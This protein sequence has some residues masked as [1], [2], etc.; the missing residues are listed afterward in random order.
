[1]GKNFLRKSCL[2]LSLIFSISS[3]C[4]YAKDYSQRFWDV[5]KDHWAFTYIAD[6]AERGVI[7]GYEDGTF[8]PSKTVSRAEW[9]K[10]MVD[11]AGLTVTDNSVNFNDTRGHW[12]NSYINSAKYYLT[13]FANGYYRPDQAATREDVTVSMVRIKG[14]DTADVDFSSLMS[15]TDLDSISNYA[16]SYV[17]IAI[18]NNLIEG[19]DDG[20]FRG[21]DTLTR[22]EAAALMYRAFKH[23]NADKIVDIP[24]KP[25]SDTTSTGSSEDIK[26]AEPSKS[27]PSSESTDSEPTDEVASKYVVDT[28]FEANV[29]YFEYG[30]YNLVR[31]D[32]IWCYDGTSNIYYGNYDDGYIHC[33][34]ISSNKDKKLLDL[35]ELDDKSDMMQPKLFSIKSICY[36]SNRDGLLIHGYFNYSNC[37]V[38]LLKDTG[39]VSLITDEFVYSPYAIK[40][41]LGNGNYLVNSH[42]TFKDLSN[43][44]M[45]V[46]HK[47]YDL[48]SDVGMPGYVNTAL[49]DS[50]DLYLTTSIGQLVKYDYKDFN[51]IYSPSKKVYASGLSD[52]YFVV[53]DS[54]SV[55]FANHAGESV[56]TINS[57]DYDVLDYN[58]VDFSNSDGKLIVM[59]DGSIIFYDI[60]NL[61][62]RIIRER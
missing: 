45:I 41:C 35:S 10:M 23:G 57:N 1:M 4:V 44:T 58:R 50:G 19:F 6:L 60:E 52:K 11:A 21:Q 12:A 3:Y 15:F 26:Q 51:T 43:F 53:C 9:A 49:E 33:F 47:D 16:K 25:V 56:Y 28:L 17:A 46:N 31:K 37:S 14:Y 54:S 32:S 22:A 36:D 34:N 2:M 5:K 48:I 24:D 61:S 7:N 62:F 18:D 30:Y 20:S 40:Y 42:N 39:E 59:D 29:P 55:F 38:Y 13:G 8:K 27:T